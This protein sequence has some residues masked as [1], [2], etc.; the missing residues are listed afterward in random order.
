MVDRQSVYSSSSHTYHTLSYS[1]LVES[2]K[3]YPQDL[4]F[5]LIRMFAASFGALMVPL[6][7]LSAVQLRL[8]NPAAIL[9]ALM[10][11]TDISI[12]NISRL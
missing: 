7:Y 11:L 10:V 2:E 3:T 6:A 8:S 5:P 1:K 9:T 4:N 12:L